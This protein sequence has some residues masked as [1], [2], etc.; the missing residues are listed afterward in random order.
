MRIYDS[1]TKEK[2]SLNKKEVSIYNCGPTVYNHIHIGNARPLIT[3]DVIYRYLKFMDYDV[4]YVLNITDIDDKIIQKA[5]DENKT[6]TEI[7]E[8]Y[9]NEYLKI[10]NA[11]NILKMKI[12][13]VSEHIDDIISYIQNI[14]EK[15][16]AYESDGDVYFFTDK[17]QNYGEVSNNNLDVLVENTRIVNKTNKNN[18]YDFVL[19]KKTN[20]GLNWKSNWSVGRPGW[21]TECSCLINKY[22]GDH[23]DIHGGGIDLKFPHHE[24]EN[25][26][27]YAI[28]NQKL[29]SIWLHFVMINIDGKKMSKSLNNFILLK[30]ILSKYNYQTIKW[31]FYQTKLNNPLNYSDVNIDQAQK[32]IEK[33]KQTINKTKTYL[34]IDNLILKSTPIISDEFKNE[35]ENNI[36]LPNIVSLIWEK[37]KMMNIAKNNKDRLIVYKYLYELITELSILGIEFEELHT[38]SIIS[39][40]TKYKEY[41]KEKQYEK[42]DEIRKILIEKGLL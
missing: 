22:I 12:V 27:N 11:M 9:F 18:N 37:I 33:I 34:L 1:L 8:Y 10:L 32:D 19:W 28:H 7:S 39:L 4:N 20:K 41:I 2:V 29:A 16:Y 26:Q 13:K 24:N 23:V 21:H 5:I 36:N 35:M 30:D 25:A 14:K 3:M 15:G 42:S 6:E 31:F 40:I 17:V 38:P